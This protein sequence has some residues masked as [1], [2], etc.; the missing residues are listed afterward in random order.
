MRIFFFFLYFPPETAASMYLGQNLIHQILENGD[1]VI[2]CVPTPSRGVDKN[3]WREY[4]KKKNRQ[5]H[6][7]PNLHI[8]RFLMYIE[9]QN[10]VLRAIRY[11]LCTI[12][13]IYYAF[14]FD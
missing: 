11:F 14:K 12:M 2:V 3:V 13:Y 8:Y 10:P 9:V 6:I 7:T 4:S 5:N 1:E